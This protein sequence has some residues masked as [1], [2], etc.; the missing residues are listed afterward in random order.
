MNFGK[1]ICR[2]LFS[3]T[4]T[5]IKWKLTI[6]IYIL[7]LTESLFIF[8][9]CWNQESWRLFSS[10]LFVYVLVEIWREGDILRCNVLEVRE[11]HTRRARISSLFCVKEVEK[12]KYKCVGEEQEH[13]N[14]VLREV[15][16]KRGFPYFPHCPSG[17]VVRKLAGNWIVV[18]L[19]ATCTM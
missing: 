19:W 2:C 3:F 16:T 14:S 9:Q 7:H 15:A 13:H 4:S 10:V 1:C 18:A 17:S 8:T 5:L 11:I 12:A 6:K